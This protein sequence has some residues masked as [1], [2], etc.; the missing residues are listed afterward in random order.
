MG[1][2][3][4]WR[5]RAR[6]VQ[7]LSGG[8]DLTSMPCHGGDTGQPA[9]ASARGA[10]SKSASTAHRLQ[11]TFVLFFGAAAEIV[12]SESRICANHQEIIA[13]VDPLVPRSRGQNRDISCLEFECPASRS[14]EAHTDVAASDPKHLMNLGVVVDIIIDAV[15]PR[16]LPSI[17]LEQDLE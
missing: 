8:A 7:A 9:A 1:A 10:S 6:A 17:A 16:A 4:R 11:G 14:T 2:A 12:L 13:F 15:S 3:R 5:H